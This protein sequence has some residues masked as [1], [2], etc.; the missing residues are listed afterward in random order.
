M[1][2]MSTIFLL[3]VINIICFYFFKKEMNVSF[4]YHD[5]YVLIP[6]LILARILSKVRYFIWSITLVLGMLLIIYGNA[7]TKNSECTSIG[8][9]INAYGLISPILLGAVTVIL[10]ITQIIQY[11]VKR[12]KEKNRINNIA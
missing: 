3:V 10:I 2:N 1:K 5:L 9:D 7:L 8:C 12:S 4:S 6:I 11:F